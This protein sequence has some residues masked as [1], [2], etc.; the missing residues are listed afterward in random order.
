M[1]WTCDARPTVAF[2]AAEPVPVVLVDN[3]VTAELSVNSSEQSN[4]VSLCLDQA[5]ISGSR[6]ILGQFMTSSSVWVNCHV[7][8]PVSFLVRVTRADIC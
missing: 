6:D 8:V 2:P 5:L 3:R 1:A 4:D 7:T